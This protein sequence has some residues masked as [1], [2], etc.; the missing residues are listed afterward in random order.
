MHKCEVCGK[1]LS[2]E[3]SLRNH[4]KDKHEIVTKS[5]IK[6][7]HIIYLSLAVFILLLGFFSFRANNEPGEND[8]FAKCLTENGARFYGAFWCPHC[9]EQKNL[10][11]KSV[12]FINYVECSTPD[13]DAQTPLCI[14]A[15]I[16]GYPTWEFKDG[17]RM[18]G[19]V[20]LK[21]L[22]EK[23]GCSLEKPSESL[24]TN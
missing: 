11:G 3:E 5:L 21:E 22:G 20:S 7:R 1:E 15:R 8:D 17:S 9:K 6:T 16:T 10:F 14:G 2:S 18:S 4:K 24:K 12:K 13:G 19:L 23:T